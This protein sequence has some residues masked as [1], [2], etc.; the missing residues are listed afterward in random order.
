MLSR[1]ESGRAYDPLFPADEISWVFI[2]RFFCS[3]MVKLIQEGNG[4]V[5]RNIILFLQK[6]WHSRSSF[7][8]LT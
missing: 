2:L 8:L 1:M 5:A 3:N 7:S 4:G 6:K